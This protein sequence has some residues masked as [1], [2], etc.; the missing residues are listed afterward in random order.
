M[1][2]WDGYAWFHAKSTKEFEIVIKSN[3][4]LLSIN[5]PPRQTNRSLV[6]KVCETRFADTKE[7]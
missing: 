4:Y 3:I 1:S 7:D 6:K 2:F 5:S